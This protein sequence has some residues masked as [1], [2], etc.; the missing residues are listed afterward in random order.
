M[1]VIANAWHNVLR[2]RGRNL[3]LGAIILV[4][5]VSSVVALLINNTTTSIIN[6]YKGRFGSE[7]VISPDMEKVRE[8]ALSNATGGR[9]MMRAPQ[10]SNDLLL[11]FGTSE[12][13]S[14][15]EYTARANVNSEQLSAIDEDKGGGGGPMLGRAG[16]GGQQVTEPLG[17][18]FYFQLLGNSFDDFESGERTLAEGRFPE[19]VNEC[20][21]SSDLAQNNG[22]EVGDAITATGELT[23]PGAE[24]D[25]ESEA[26][27]ETKLTSY[28]LK[29]VGIYD[30][31]T[32]EYGDNMM[33]NAYTNRRNEILTTA[34]TVVA[35]YTQD[36][37]GI[38]VS[39][40]F[41]LKEPGMLEAFEQEVRAKGLSDEFNV[42]TN[43]ALYEQV[44]GPVEAMKGIVLTFM[45]VV[46]VFGAVI[47]SLLSSMAMRERKYEIG[48]LRAMGMKKGTVS[49]GLWSEMLMVTGVC[50]VAGLVIGAFAAQ[51]ITNILLQQQIDAA[52]AANSAGA[53]GAADA[54]G[55]AGA[56]GAAPPGAASSMSSGGLRAAPIGGGP[57]GFNGGGSA[58]VEPLSEVVISLG[59]D[60]A[61]EITC[62]ALVLAT[63]AALIAI[64][65]ITKYEPIKILMNRD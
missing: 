40:T 1:Y 34:E 17:T 54:T 30:D 50:L 10:V 6:D 25:P 18:V 26:A 48:V 49:L 23:A 15:A 11:A 46:L 21:I 22:I 45:A 60:T 3:L 52:T 53:F 27:A 20:V 38:S 12:Y 44:V 47:M 5:I 13:L 62:I 2:N 8:A 7:V 55:A 57:A 39:A 32:A 64:S 31:A 43:S 16:P 19:S 9:V 56:M 58:G 51:P 24:P 63:L 28:P 41:Y 14:A 61:L 35:P 36:W 29:V 42:T 4:V 37:T 59:L 65:R 33:E